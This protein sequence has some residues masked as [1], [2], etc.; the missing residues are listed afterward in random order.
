MGLHIYRRGEIYWWRIRFLGISGPAHVAFSLNVSVPAFAKLLG[1]SL[2]FEALRLRRISEHGGMDAKDLKTKLILKRD[3]DLERFKFE[4]TPAAL[5]RLAR[6]EGDHF[7]GPVAEHPDLEEAPDDASLV[8]VAESFD[9]H[10]LLAASRSQRRMVQFDGDGLALGLHNEVD[11]DAVMAVVYRRI[12]TLGAR[13]G[14]KPDDE[15]DL[16]ASG[17]RGDEIVVI[18]NTL[19]YLS[20]RED[21]TDWALGP[22]RKEIEA[23][24]ITVGIR[25]SLDHTHIIRRIVLVRRTKLLETLA[26]IPGPDFYAISKRSSDNV[27]RNQIEPPRFPQVMAE[28]SIRTPAPGQIPA[29]ADMPP[30]NEQTYSFAQLVENFIQKERK[31]M[32]KHTE[33]QYRSIGALFVKTCETDNPRKMAQSHIGAYFDNLALLPKSYG[34]SPKDAARS[35]AEIIQRGK[36]MVTKGIQSDDFIGLDPPTINRHVTQL[37]KLLMYAKG[38]GYE[39]GDIATLQSF[40][41]HD[42]ECDEDKRNAFDVAMSIILFSTSPWAGCLNEDDRLTPGNLIV[43]SSLFFVPMLGCYDL[44][45]LSEAV[46]IM[47]DDIDLDSE[48]PCINIRPNE[49]RD[50]TKTRTRTRR[51]PIHDELM[52]LGFGRYVKALRELGFRTLWPELLIRGQNTDLGDLFSKDWTP[53]LDNALPEARQNKQTFQSWRSA[54]NTFLIGMEPTISMVTR[55]QL[56]GH[57]LKDV[58]GRHYT[59]QLPDAVK[60]AGLR[61]LPIVTGHLQPAEIRLSQSVLDFAAQNLGPNKGFL[62]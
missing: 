38:K 16:R 62:I 25:P 56:M 12:L 43:H 20:D 32:G 17:L 41:Q 60:L 22:S 28:S 44:L 13:A 61:H 39:I 36:E 11:V 23:A 1:A 48:I 8:A 57:A 35:I 3:E 59:K 42:P 37:S 15:D 46:G 14:L 52:R 18:R 4:W 33:R 54:G 53:A 30:E 40:R 10:D 2:D 9:D 58:N 47:L 49:I 45:S 55:Y 31:S 19:L 21:R 29:A 7:D 34:R 6:I 24:L 5:A 51:Q 27:L 50:R 26:N